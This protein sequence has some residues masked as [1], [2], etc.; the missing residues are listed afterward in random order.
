M[1]S[2]GDEKKGQ[3]PSRTA[4]AAHLDVSPRTLRELVQNG[5]IPSD[6]SLDEGRILYIRHLRETAAGR[7]GES[8]LS[9]TDERAKRREG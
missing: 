3:T 9:L 2:G 7:S 8:G 6:A 1:D 4:M 5:I